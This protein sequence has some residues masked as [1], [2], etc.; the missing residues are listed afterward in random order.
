MADGI[1]QPTDAGTTRSTAG[2][3]SGEGARK[4]LVTST[5]RSVVVSAVVSGITASKGINDGRDGPPGPV[6]PT[7][8]EGPVGPPGPMGPAGADGRDGSP[9]QSIMPDV[10][11]GSATLTATTFGSGAQIPFTSGS[12]P[13]GGK[14]VV[15]AAGKYIV[16]MSLRVS[17]RVTGQTA[18]VWLKHRGGNLANLTCAY[19]GP[20][21]W[22]TDVTQKV[23][24]CVA[25]DEMLFSINAFSPNGAVDSSTITGNLLMIRIPS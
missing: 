20:L 15:R 1:E 6:G 5:L 3:G 17:F 22:M 8:P 23:I 13:V 7:G 18:S 19:G 2:S 21:S 4:A 24:D 10:E 12:N 14:I 11:Y 9:G 16:R 25:G